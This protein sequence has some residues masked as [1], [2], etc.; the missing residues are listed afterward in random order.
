VAGRE[1]VDT[2]ALDDQLLGDAIRALELDVTLNNA[3]RAE[4]DNALAA[5]ERAND[6]QRRGDGAGADRALDDG[7]A[8]IA[9]ARERIAGR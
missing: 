9:A 5:Y 8:A 4:Y 6:L 3:G 1:C 7:L 2:D